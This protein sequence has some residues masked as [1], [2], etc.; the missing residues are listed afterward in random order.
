MLGR[1]ANRAA[2]SALTIQY[3]EGGVWLP[4]LA[5][6]LDAP[7]ARKGPE[8]VFVSHAHA[9][10]TAAHR[11][12]IFSAPTAELM[13]ARIRGQRVEHTLSFGEGR[14][15]TGNQ[16][17]YR[18]TL[19]P[20]GHILGSAM[21]LIEHAGHTLLYT[22]DFKTRPNLSSEPCDPALAVGCETLIMET[23]FGRPAYQFPPAERVL[24]D[25]IR[26]CREALADHATPVL[27]AYSLGKGQEVL[28]GLADCGLPIAIHPGVWRM[29]KI[30]EQF[31][32]RFP[33]HELLEPDRAAG[34]VLICPPQAVKSSVVQ[35]LG[36]VR[37]AIV[38]G[39]AVEPGCR[40]RYGTDAAFPLSDH[41]DFPELIAFVKRVAPKT[42]LTLHGFAADFAQSLREV[43]FDARA[44]SEHEQLRL[45]L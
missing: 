27:L 4:Q 32:C 17:S 24:D 31:R 42:V 40:F 5:L 37:T 25:V 36:R 41:A 14:E 30:Y 6:W 20:A 1:L 2:V 16:S 11:E 26:F 7:R 44:L 28:C 33:P 18:L 13:R 21:A 15:F 34:K 45:A 3:L 29:T 43:G 12:V 39:W 23:T 9:D 19:L 8:R 35:K 10:H 22:G 38:S